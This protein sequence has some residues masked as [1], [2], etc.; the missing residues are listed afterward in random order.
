M[1]RMPGRVG[2]AGSL[3]L[4]LEDP[5][6]E[7]VLALADAAASSSS[8]RPTGAQLGDAH[9]AEV[10]DVEV[11]ALARGFELRALSS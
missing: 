7:V 8:S 3:G 10:A 4:A 9:R 2:V 1:S 11:V 5:I 6:D